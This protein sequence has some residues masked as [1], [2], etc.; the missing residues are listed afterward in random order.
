MSLRAERDSARDRRAGSVLRRRS[1]AEEQAAKRDRGRTLIQRKGVEIA[2]KGIGEGDRLRGAARLPIGL[3]PFIVGQEKL[4][5]TAL[6]R[7]QGS[8]SAAPPFYRDALLRQFLFA[9]FYG[10]ISCCRTLFSSTG[11]IGLPLWVW[12]IFSFFSSLCFF[13]FLFLYFS[14]IASS[15]LLPSFAAVIQP[16]ATASSP[17]FFICGGDSSFRG[18]DSTFRGV[19]FVGD[20]HGRFVPLSPPLPHPRLP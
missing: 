7:P 3:G 12:L 4:V 2:Q 15:R 13:S 1:C 5:V 18:G 17:D 8:G 19:V 10:K 11:S 16:F 9:A 20:G 6:I 14:F